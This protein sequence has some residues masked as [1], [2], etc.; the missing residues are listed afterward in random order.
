MTANFLE[1]DVLHRTQVSLDLILSHSSRGCLCKTFPSTQIPAME[2]TIFLEMNFI[3]LL[4]NISE[5][6][7]R[8]SNKRPDINFINVLPFC[9]STE[10][11]VL[12]DISL[13]EQ[14]DFSSARVALVPS[15]PG[16]HNAE[17]PFS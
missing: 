5:E 1:S 14:C 6:S 2:M 7:Q 3:S 17:N 13:F 8:L 4:W 9:S 16:P 15:V 12:A 10:L 11:T